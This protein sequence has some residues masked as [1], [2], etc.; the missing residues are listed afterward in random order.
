MQLRDSFPRVLLA[1]SCALIG[2]MN[3]A[4]RVAFVMIGLLCLA[5][6]EG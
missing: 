5:A 3:E 2:V 1:A 6:G 4:S